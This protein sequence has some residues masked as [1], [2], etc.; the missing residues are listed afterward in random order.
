MEEFETIHQDMVDILNALGLGDHARP[1]SM[2]EIVQ[3]EILPAIRSLVGPTYPSIEKLQARVDALETNE[4][5]R[6]EIR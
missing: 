6:R 1:I 4:H 3:T 2:H 5:S